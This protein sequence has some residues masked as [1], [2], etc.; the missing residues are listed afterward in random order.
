MFNR[1]KKFMEL[2]SALRDDLADAEQ[3]RHAALVTAD[4]TTDPFIRELERARAER[5]ERRAVSIDR[6]L[7][8]LERAL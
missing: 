8:K 4:N 3:E 1:R 7:R 5:Y 6:R 2:C